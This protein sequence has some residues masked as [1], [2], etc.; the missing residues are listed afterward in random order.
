MDALTAI[1]MRVLGALLEKAVT[2]PDQVNAIRSASNQKSSRE[3]V[4]NLSDSDVIQALQ[5]LEDKLLV[6]PDPNLRG[7][8]EKYQQRFCK[9]PF[10][11]YDFNDAQ[12]A[13]LTVLM[14]RGP[15]TP[16]EIRTRTDRMHKFGNNDAVLDTL[17]SLHN[18]TPDA[19]VTEL[20]KAP[21]RRDS[22]W[23]QLFG[24][25][26]ESYKAGTKSAP[27][28]ATNEPPSPEPDRLAALESRVS[29]LEAALARLQNGSP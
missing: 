17:H 20:P 4:M 29:N 6:S 9:P 25:D 21:N 28:P 14:L 7:R 12:Y 5:S 19:L 15:A 3:P 24:E 10:G 16:G 23:A 2:T 8:V 1:E 27:E 26:A 18:W 13:V 22:C 11:V